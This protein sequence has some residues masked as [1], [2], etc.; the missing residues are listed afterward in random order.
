MTTETVGTSGPASVTSDSL[1]WRQMTTHD[2]QAVRVALDVRIPPA[3]WGGVQ[4]V[5][6]GLADGLSGLS[7]NDEYL[8]L[9]RPD[10]KDWLVPR[11]SGGA[12]AIVV[13]TSSGTTLRR[14][15]FERV[16]NTIPG[17]G[18]GLERVG[19]AL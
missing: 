19:R 10:A 16:S 5:A 12:K 2:E 9:V 14:R 1:R 7:G 6:E 11:L 13:P 15:V 18:A 3:A 4:Q 8:F 17:I